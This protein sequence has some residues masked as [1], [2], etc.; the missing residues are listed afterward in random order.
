[1]AHF[2]TLRTHSCIYWVPLFPIKSETKSVD[3]N[4]FYTKWILR[5]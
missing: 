4:D 1:M 2:G 5:G 3:N